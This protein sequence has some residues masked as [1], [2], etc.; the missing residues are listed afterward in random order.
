[1]GLRLKP[2]ELLLT[3]PGISVLIEDSAGAA[4]AAM[5]RA[6]SRSRKWR[7]AAGIVASATLGEIR[8]A[9]FDVIANPTPTFPTHA[10]LIHPDGVA[11]FG[12]ENLAILA[13]AFQTTTGN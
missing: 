9:G 5:R 13:A 1:V 3:P 7:T 8:S 10:R 6:Y 11:G 4:A 2:Q 12:E